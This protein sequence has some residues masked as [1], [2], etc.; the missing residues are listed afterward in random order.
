MVGT[1]T[2]ITKPKYFILSRVHGT[3]PIERRKSMPVLPILKSRY[4]NSLFRFIVVLCTRG[5]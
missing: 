5:T 2:K 3:Y 1:C 4:G